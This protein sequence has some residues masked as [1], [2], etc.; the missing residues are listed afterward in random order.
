MDQRRKINSAEISS[1]KVATLPGEGIIGLTRVF[2]YAGA[3]RVIAS[4]WKAPDPCDQRSRCR[5]SSILRECLAI[6]CQ[7]LHA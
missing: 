5:A 6:P 7:P 1:S 4:L 2:M 3:P